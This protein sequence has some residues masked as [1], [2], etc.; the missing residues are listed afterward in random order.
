MRNSLPPDEEIRAHIE[1][2]GPIKN[3]DLTQ[4]AA[5]VIGR[6][7]TQRAL[8]R[9]LDRLIAAGHIQRTQDPADRR[10][11]IYNARTDR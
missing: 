10:K 11:K 5:R 9:A 4:W 2:H 3:V 7:L 1:A 8:E 6:R